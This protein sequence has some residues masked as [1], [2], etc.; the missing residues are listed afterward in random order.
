[1]L[2]A[3]ESIGRGFYSPTLVTLAEKK[4]LICC[5]A[6][7]LQKE[8]PK[9]SDP[10]DAANKSHHSLDTANKSLYH[11]NTGSAVSETGILIHYCPHCSYAT[12]NKGCL[13]RHLRIHSGERP[14]ACKICRKSFTQKGNLLRHLRLHI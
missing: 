4:N 1:M 6:I 12:P 13:A 8:Q 2:C 10:L 7:Y 14:F 9:S 11:S 3:Y 5:G